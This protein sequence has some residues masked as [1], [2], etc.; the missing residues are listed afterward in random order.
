MGIRIVR[1]GVLFLAVCLVLQGC[2]AKPKKPLKP[3]EAPIGLAPPDLETEALPA[4]RT[5][6]LKDRILAIASYEWNYFGRQNV[7]YGEEGESIPHVGYWEDDDEAH[8]DRVN[9]YWRAVDR[10]ELSGADCSEP[11]SAAFISWVM[12]VAGVPEY[13]FPSAKAHW[14]YLSQIVANHQNPDAMF[15]PRTILEYQPKPGDL[16][17]A[18][19]QSDTPLDFREVP[20]P[21][22]LA[23]TKLHCD[24]VV[25]RDGRTLSAI[26]GNVRNSVSKS[27]LKLNPEGYLQPT[28]GR[29]WFLVIEN[30]L[31]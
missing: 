31:E 19:R 23:N 7:V 16:I 1:I 29:P 6:S 21:E 20:Q 25:E 27:I 4:L 10:P 5:G 13:L 15:Y 24:I 14:V 26:G 3:A 18:D 11:W 22:W 30:H 8:M 17:C 28:P 2:A 9:R 12:R